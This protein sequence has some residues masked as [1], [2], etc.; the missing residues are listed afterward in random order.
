[1]VCGNKE[2]FGRLLYVKRVADFSGGVDLTN[3][4]EFA[5]CIDEGTVGANVGIP[6]PISVF[7]G[8]ENEPELTQCSTDQSNVPRP[9]YLLGPRNVAVVLLEDVKPTR[10]CLDPGRMGYTC[11]N[12]VRISAATHLHFVTDLHPHRSAQHD[13]PL[14]SV[15]VL[16]NDNI[17]VDSLIKHHQAPIARREI[18]IEVDTRI[19]GWQRLDEVGKLILHSD[20]R[21]S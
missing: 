16:G 1:M 19:R 12:E 17:A 8:R 2:V 14:I 6:V 4:S 10:S 18:R 7:P 5:R 3:A 11:G 15:H 13:P 20:L 21:P 9:G